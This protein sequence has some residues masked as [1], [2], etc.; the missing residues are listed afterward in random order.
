MKG[1]GPT[2]QNIILGGIPRANLLP[3]EVVQRTKSR[4][5]RKML[6]VLVGLVIVVAGSGSAAASLRAGQAQSDLLA[7]QASTQG[8]LA[9]QLTYAEATTIAGLV[10]T[11]EDARQLGTSTEVQWNGVL[12]EITTYL[13]AGAS[14]ASGSLVASTPW[15]PA[16]ITGGPLRQPSVATLSLSVT[17]G[18]ILEATDLV[19]RLAGLPGF[20]D[21]TP[22]QVSNADGVFMT[23]ITLNLNTEALSG[24]FAPPP[25]QPVAAEDEQT[26]AA[27]AENDTVNENETGTEE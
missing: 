14:L 6:G 20:V 3:P 2:R 23:T 19:R 8:L 1:I 12:D 15:A 4:G 16:P 11:I 22:T 13:P 10:T 17:S 25:E 5:T 18:E 26:A 24:R 21:A 9:E 7:A 27:T